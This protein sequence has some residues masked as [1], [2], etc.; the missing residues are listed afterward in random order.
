MGRLEEDGVEA[1]LVFGGGKS[2]RAG[3]SDVEKC[4]EGEDTASSSYCGYLP[5]SDGLEDGSERLP[6]A[7]RSVEII[8]FS[9]EI[10]HEQNGALSE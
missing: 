9:V 7:A 1:C 10:W 5:V 6:R 3:L 4:R 8:T 2:S